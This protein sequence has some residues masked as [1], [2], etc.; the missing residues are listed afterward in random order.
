MSDSEVIWY[1]RGRLKIDAE[2]SLHQDCGIL[3]HRIIVIWLNQEKLNLY[4]PGSHKVHFLL[5]HAW[6]FISFIRRV[7]MLKKCACIMF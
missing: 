6:C 3:L 5:C 2:L 1:Y 7:H 4:P